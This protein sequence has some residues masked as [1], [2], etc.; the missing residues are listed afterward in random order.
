MVSNLTKA[1]V[2]I[3][4]IAFGALNIDKGVDTAFDNNK[5]KGF[6]QLAIGA[7]CTIA[8]VFMFSSAFP[9]LSPSADE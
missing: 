9:E 8:G 4:G 5:T 2:G 1:V 3:S 6:T 7:L